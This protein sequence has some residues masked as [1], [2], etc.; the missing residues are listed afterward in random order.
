[1]ANIALVVHK[2]QL[3]SAI[4]IQNPSDRPNAGEISFK[5][6]KFGLSTNNIT[7]AML[8]DSYRY[9]EFFPVKNP[10][11]GALNVWACAKVIESQNSQINVGERIYGYFP[12]SRYHVLKP[13]TV[14]KS[15]FLVERNHLPADRLAYNQYFR[16]NGDLEYS[17]EYEDLMLIFRPLWGTAFFLDD[18]LTCNDYYHVKRVVITSASSKTAFSF[19]WFLKNR[20]FT[21]IGL[22]SNNNKEYV[23][24]LYLYDQVYSYS[25]KQVDQYEDTD[26]IGIQP[27]LGIDFAGDPVL[28]HRLMNAYGDKMIALVKVGVSHSSTLNQSSGLSVSNEKS[29]VFFAPDWIKRRLPVA[30]QSLSVRKVTA[31]H[32]FLS[33]ISK[34]TTVEYKDEKSAVQLYSDLFNSKCKPSTSFVVSLTS[35]LPKL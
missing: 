28:N 3:Q 2:H 33:H 8:G 22:T 34:Y 32:S 25:D 7:Y 13:S 4:L 17:S 18:F 12:A 31:W 1:M 27:F 29:I 35:S 26:C 9:F 14:K 5:I 11:F 15:Y 24:S 10:L 23:K 21:V 30:G 20:N 16:A 19:A 6:E